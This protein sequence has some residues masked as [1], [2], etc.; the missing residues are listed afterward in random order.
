MLIHAVVGLEPGLFTIDDLYSVKAIL[1]TPEERDMLSAYLQRKQR[2]P[3][4]FANKPPLAPSETFLIESMK[5]RDLAHMLDVFIFSIQ[6]E[7][8]HDDM[9]SK[10]KSIQQVCHQIKSSDKFK[11]LLRFVYQ[12]GSITNEQYA[13]N[14]DGTT[15]ASFKQWMGKDARSVGFK[16]DGLAKLKD[17]ASADGKW[18]LMN[19]LVD[20]ILRSKPEVVRMDEWR[21]GEKG[22]MILNKNR[23]FLTLPPLLGR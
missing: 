18:S 15:N 6:V 16:V 22:V 9:T 14:A 11:L 5:Q 3:A 4:E 20:F 8:E 21:E 2:N 13:V 7:E 1:P 17:V 19:F 12:L 23:I 10:S